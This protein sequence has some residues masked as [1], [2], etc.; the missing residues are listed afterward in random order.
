MMRVS[1]V[2]FEVPLPLLLLLL[3]LVPKEERL[4]DFGRF[5][6]RCIIYDDRIY[7]AIICIDDVDKMY[8]LLSLGSYDT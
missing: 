5:N 1:T 7:G 8:L 3:L 6:T 2:L 4:K